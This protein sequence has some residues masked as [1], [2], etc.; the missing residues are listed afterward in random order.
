MRHLAGYVLRRVPLD[1]QGLHD[2]IWKGHIYPYPPGQCPICKGTGFNSETKKLADDF[3][4]FKNT[5]CCWY[6]KIT[7]DEVQALVDAKRLQQ[8]V[9][10]SLNSGCVPTSDEVNEWARINLPGHD[11]TNK[12]ILVETRA[13]RRRVYGK[14]PDCN[15]ETIIFRC[16]DDKKT[17]MSWGKHNPPIGDG[18]QLWEKGSTGRPISPVFESAEEL[19]NWYSEN[20]TIVTKNSRMS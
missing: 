20:T 16:M 13:K 2:K 19:A 8:F 14:C 17:Y 6:D 10:V 11:L 7:Q 3:Y 4:D 9:C 12:G 1:F 18:F 15:G 5:G